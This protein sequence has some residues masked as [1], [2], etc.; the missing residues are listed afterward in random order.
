MGRIVRPWYGADPV[1]RLPFQR[2][3]RRH[4]GHTVTAH[5]HPGYLIYRHEGLDI[6]GREEPVPVEIRFEASPLYDTYGLEPQDYPRVFADSGLASPHRMPD[7]SLCLFY[8]GDPP[9]R[10]WTA[11]AG[12]LALL[13]LAGDHLFFET[14]WRHS[15]G[16]RGGRWLAPEAPHGYRGRTQ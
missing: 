7:G 2:N 16:H 12:L 11:E 13:D 6:P 3:A 9:E 14:Y 1:W 10:R 5:L 15:G 4:Y 8:P